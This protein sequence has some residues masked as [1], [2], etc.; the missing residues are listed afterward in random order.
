MNL[1]E[2]LLLTSIILFLYLTALSVAL[3]DGRLPSYLLKVP[4]FLVV[5]IM[6][7]AFIIYSGFAVYLISL[8]WAVQY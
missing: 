1:P 6:I 2:Q 8:V 3:Y 5:F 7:F 4:A